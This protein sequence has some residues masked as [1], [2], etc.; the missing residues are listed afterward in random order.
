[1]PKKDI[2]RTAQIL[3][4]TLREGPRVPR[5]TD[6]GDLVRELKKLKVSPGEV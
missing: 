1:M 3:G 2:I 5:L 6:W 4:K